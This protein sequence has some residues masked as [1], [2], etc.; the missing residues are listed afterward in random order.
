MKDFFITLIL[1]I[2][3]V[4]I[5]AGVGILGINVYNDINI[6]EVGGTV[7]NLISD[8]GV[9]ENDEKEYSTNETIISNNDSSLTNIESVYSTQEKNITYSN[10]NSKNN[11]F[12]NQLN[13]Y[14]KTIYNGLQNNIENLKTGTYKV[15]F[16]NSFSN[17]LSQENGQETLGDYY[18]A[19]IEAFIYEN[20]SVFYLNVNKMYLN[21]ESTKYSNRTTY[22]VYISSG[23]EKSYLADGFSS[24]V[25]V[26]ACEKQIETIKNQ[27]FSAIYGLTDYQKILKIHDYLVDN[28]SYD[29]TL[30]KSNIYNLYG[31]LVKKEC[32]CE[33]YSKAFKYLL[34]EAGIQNVIVIGKA[35]NSEGKSE[36][37]SWNYVLLNNTWYAIDVTW[38]D[39]II[40]G[41]GTLSNK[42]KYKYFL[43]GQTTINKDHTPSGQFTT[44]GKIFNYPTLS[45][46][47]YK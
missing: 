20:P 8:I 10:K 36:N 11:Y 35:T 42:S 33:G 26:E 14:S 17:V 24:K 39:P 1:V 16:G 12:Y 9:T 27:V 3:I 2:V 6:E 18:Q 41:G 21:I 30:A 45:K 43:K 28:T 44:N 5:I 47:D 15:E 40:R 46:V 34:D 31:A 25:Q 4:L 38:D 19:A 37:H 7:Q 29:S 22:N 32:V 13:E 23:N